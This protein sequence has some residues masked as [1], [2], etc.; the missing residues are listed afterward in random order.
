MFLFKVESNEKRRPGTGILILK[1]N[2][3]R[4]EEKA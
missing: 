2:S 4:R 1:C 3:K